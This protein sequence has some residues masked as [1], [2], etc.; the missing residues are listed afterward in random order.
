[1]VRNHKGF[2]RINKSLKLI[3]DRRSLSVTQRT[4]YV[5]AVPCVMEKP[6]ISKKHFPIVTN[7]YEDFVELHA[8]ATAG[9][10][11]LDGPGSAFSRMMM[12]PNNGIHGTGSFLPWHR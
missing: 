1:M 3:V 5:K 11:K 7:R 6:P 8:N 12:G 2:I 4:A 10:A 9:G